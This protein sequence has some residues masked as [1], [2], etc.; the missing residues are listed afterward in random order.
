[1]KH[2][3]TSLILLLILVPVLGWF[4][5][6]FLLTSWYAPTVSPRYFPPGDVQT[7]QTIIKDA[8][9][10]GSALLLKSTEQPQYFLYEPSRNSTR[11]ADENEWEKSQEK[12]IDCWEQSTPDD[13]AGPSYG[14]YVLNAKRSPDN[15][16]IA[17]LSAYGPKLPGIS[18]GLGGAEKIWGTRYLEIKENPGF[19]NIQKPVR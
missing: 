3:K 13:Y 16:K 11:N 8:D 15:S 17:V 2:R 5:M 7:Q 12:E 10:T 19:S 6:D 1:M 4:L 9:S 18:L 14:H